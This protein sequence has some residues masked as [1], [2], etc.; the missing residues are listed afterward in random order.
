MMTLQEQ[1]PSWE[2]RD[3]CGREATMADPAKPYSCEELG[4]HRSPRSAPSSGGRL[5][6]MEVIKSIV[7]QP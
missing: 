2:W 7:L 5:Q 3:G 1:S 6:S 4:M